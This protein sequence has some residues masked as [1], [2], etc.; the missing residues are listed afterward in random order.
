MRGAAPEFAR[1]VRSRPTPDVLFASSMLSLA[2]FI[3]LA[4][5]RI[6]RVPRILYFH[7]NQ[8][9]YPLA[10]GERRDLHLVMTQITSSLAADRI[11]FNSAHQR[12]ELLAAL[13]G[14]LRSLPDRKPV[15]L[16]RHFRERSAVF[17]PGVDFASLEVAAGRAPDGGPPV[18]LWNHRWEHDKGRDLFL[19]LLRHLI[20]RRLRFRIAVTGAPRGA[21]SDLFDELPR[22]A[23]SRLAHIGFARSRQAYAGL[24]GGAR[25]VVSTARHEFFGISV[26]EAVWAGAFPLLPLGLSYPEI[27]DPSRHSDCYYRS[28][29]ELYERAAQYLREGPPSAAG[30]RA[31]IARFAWPE[32]VRRFDDLIDVLAQSRV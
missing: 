26:L 17:P 2:E 23:G 20:R 7:E 22:V 28:K 3:G 8:L 15:G 21:R 19:D 4:E 6:R 29:E 13:P 14:F 10:E 16:A 1:A 25:L 9:T 30:L 12:K 27:L 24:L 11:L 18:L 32:T 31:E 5:E